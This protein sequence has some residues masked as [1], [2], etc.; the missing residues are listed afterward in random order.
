MHKIL[1]RRTRKPYRRN[2]V[3]FLGCVIE[4]ALA[5]VLRKELLEERYKRVTA[6]TFKFM[7]ALMIGGIELRQKRWRGALNIESS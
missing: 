1:M 2:N 3:I 5:I 7:A 4:A 6:L